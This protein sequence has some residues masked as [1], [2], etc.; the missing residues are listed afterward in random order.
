[1]EGLFGRKLR[2][3]SAFLKFPESNVNKLL[4]DAG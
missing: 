2:E 1:M 4:T 3:K